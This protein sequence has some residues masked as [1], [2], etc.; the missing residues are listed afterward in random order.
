MLETKLR[1]KKAEQNR[2]FFSRIRDPNEDTTTRVKKRARMGG[3]RSR[4]KDAS[5]VGGV[6]VGEEEE[7]KKKE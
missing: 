5:S 7:E 4:V 6:K 3:R 1:I 2:C